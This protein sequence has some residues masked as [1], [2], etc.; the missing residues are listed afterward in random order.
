LG[1]LALALRPR[2][3]TLVITVASQEGAPAKDVSVR[4]DGAVRCSASPCEVPDLEPGAHLVSASAAGFPPSA[5][6][7]VSVEA[8]KHSA[9]HL[10]LLPAAATEMSG[11]SVVAVGDGLHV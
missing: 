5:V 6:R 10:A 7:A 2:V 1:A 3:G 8:G 11:L 4:V 9:E